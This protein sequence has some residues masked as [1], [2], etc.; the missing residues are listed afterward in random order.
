MWKN[1]KCKLTVHYDDGFTLREE[2][3]GSEGE[4]LWAH[5]FENLRMS[6]DDGH[7]LLWLDFVDIGEQVSFFFVLTFIVLS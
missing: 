5:P 4:I 1:K 2:Q 6:S 3:E 7:R